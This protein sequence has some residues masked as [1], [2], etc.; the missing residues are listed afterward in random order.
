MGYQEALLYVYSGTG[1][2][3]R[4]AAW[5]AETLRATGATAIVCPIVAGISPVDEPSLRARLLAVVLPTHGFTAPWGVL[6][7]VV[8]LPAGR[9]TEAAVVATRAGSR[10]GAWYTPGLEGTAAWLVALLLLLKGYNL[11]AVVG[12]DMPSNWMALHPALASHTIAGILV[13]ARRR[14]GVL[15]TALLADRRH[16]RGWIPLALGLLLLPVSLGYLLI[17]RFFLGKLFF[18]SNAC[19]GC[20]LCANHCPNHAIRL[21]A[22]RHGRRPYWTFH[23]ESC[24]RCMAY[25]PTQA[26]EVSHLL[27]LG[28]VWLA[29]AVP[30]ATLLS[31]LTTRLPALAFLRAVP[32]SISWS[33]L[34]VLLIGL[35]YPLFSLLLRIGWLNRLFTLLTLTHYYRR[36]HEPSTTLKDL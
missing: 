18:A 16:L 27:A 15:M 32:T 14:V 21:R 23:C 9:G 33:I 31:W 11:R 2:S 8:R 19:T 34:L 13:H 35:L 25:C 30:L 3:F 24:M 10:L 26:V 7:L 6:R 17:G 36:Y 20:G 28:V 4:V 22:T 12:I 29:S 5:M 1:N